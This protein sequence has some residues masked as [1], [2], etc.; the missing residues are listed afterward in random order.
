MTRIFGG[1]SVTS[2]EQHPYMAVVHRL[3]N[4]GVGKCSGTIISNRWVLT[5]GHCVV[6]YPQ[7]FFV[8]FGIINK[9]GIGYDW[10]VGPGVSMITTEAVLHPQYH[11]TYNDIALLRMPRD[12]HF[13]GKFV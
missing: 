9:S 10:L 5:A 7:I 13:S 12:I 3:L 11:L 6:N 4:N 8:V 1:S 2:A